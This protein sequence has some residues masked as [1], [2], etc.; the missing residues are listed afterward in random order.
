MKKQPGK[1]A[2]IYYLGVKELWSLWRD[3]VMLILI[4]FTF[5]FSVYSSATSMPDTLNNAPIAIAD[6]DHS[7]LSQR[8]ASAFSPP[9]FTRPFMI[10]QAEVDLGMDSGIYTFALIIPPNFQRDVLAGRDAQIQL[11]TD[12]TRMTQAFIGS[13]F[14]QQVISGEIDEFIKRYRDNPPPPVALEL[15][16]R[17]NPM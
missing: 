10:D 5:T 13:G 7:R 17:F 15:R 3:P 2:N 8:I 4:V 6:E 1:I 9:H 11:N 16:A 12:A 14:I